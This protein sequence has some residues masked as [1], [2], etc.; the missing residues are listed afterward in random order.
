MGLFGPPDSWARPGHSVA[1][2]VASVALS[3]L[4]WTLLTVGAQG[5]GVDITGS[6]TPRKSVVAGATATLTRD[7]DKVVLTG[8]VAMLFNTG[9]FSGPNRAEKV[10][11][12]RL[13]P[14]GVRSEAR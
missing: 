2:V 10:N 14:D 1:G 11:R 6:I 7:G 5:P 12:A 9:S 4:C 8:S 3:V 13:T